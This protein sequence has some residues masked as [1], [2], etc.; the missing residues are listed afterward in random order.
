MMPDPEFLELVPFEEPEEEKNLSDLGNSQ[1]FVEVF[2]RDLRW[3]ASMPG[4][5][6]MWWDRNVWRPDGKKLVVRLAGQIAREWRERMPEIPPPL[7]EE[8]AAKMNDEAIRRHNARRVA[9]EKRR[10]ALGKHA[11]KCESAGSIKSMVELATAH[12]RI[13]VE[14]DAWD[15]DEWLVNTPDLTWDARTMQSYEPGRADLIT[16]CAGVGAGQEG[17]PTWLRFLDRVMGGDQDMIAF[18]QRAV[19]YSLTGNTGEQCLFIAYGGGS[20]GKSTFMEVVQH[21]LGDY[22]TTTQVA[23]FVGR[24]EGGIPNDLAALAGVRLVVCSETPEGGGLDEGL[25]KAVTGGDLISARFLNR[26]FFTFK[27]R[28]KL[29]FLTN[30]KPIIKG[31]DDGIWR[32]IRLVPFEQK[33]LDH[34]K[35]K[36]LPEKLK[37]EA[38]GIMR[39]ALEGLAEWRRIGLSPPAVVTEATAEYRKDMDIL[40]GFL[41]DRCTMGETLVAPN[42]DVYL[43]YKSW[44]EDQGLRVQ[45]HKWLTRQLL[46]RGYKQDPGRAS[47]REWLGFSILVPGKAPKPW[48]RPDQEILY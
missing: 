4:S 8:R 6:W 22:A 39:W 33:I 41:A 11:H 26:E 12:A 44:A 20:N 10:E 28:F 29:W 1:L 36:G 16:R 42:K 5:G 7:S 32:R 35:D 23:T 25:V 43:A 19:G 24:K 34:E 37:A 31:A 13:A 15:A 27:P 48:G 14:K 30:H 9:A 18:L 46:D 38:C 17:C 47:G 45:S 2:G 21:I 3:C 40:G